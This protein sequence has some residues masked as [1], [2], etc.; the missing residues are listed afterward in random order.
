[1]LAF[2]QVFTKPSRGEFLRRLVEFLDDA[3]AL[4]LK[5]IEGG[6][7]DLAIAGTRSRG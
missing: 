4:R 7:G 1:M 5:S 6:A 2:F 3:C